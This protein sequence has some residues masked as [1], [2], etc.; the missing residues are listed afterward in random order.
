MRSAEQI[1]KDIIVKAGLDAEYRSRL[2]DNPRE[3]VSEVV[4]AALSDGLDVR[5][6]VESPDCYHLALP[7]TR[8]LSTD[9]LAAAAGGIS[10]YDYGPNW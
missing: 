9:Q 7:Q 2:L 3:A 5:V 1:K 6:H 10:A 8:R 4:G